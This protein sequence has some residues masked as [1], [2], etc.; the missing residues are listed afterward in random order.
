MSTT[1]PSEFIQVCSKGDIKKFDQLFSSLSIDQKNEFIR[2][3]N[4]ACFHF[5]A[6]NGHHQIVKTIFNYVKSVTDE[7]PIEEAVIPLFSA[8]NGESFRAAL[9]NHHIKTVELILVE[10]FLFDVCLDIIAEN[11]EFLKIIWNSPLRVCILYLFNQ[12]CGRDILLVQHM[13]EVLPK[14][15]QHLLIEHISDEYNILN[16]FTIH[17]LSPFKTACACNKLDIVQFLWGLFSLPHQIKM[18]ETQFPSCIIIAAKN[19]HL[20]IIK[21]LAA[22]VKSERKTSLLMSMDFSA[23]IYAAD[24]GYIEIMQFIWESLPGSLRSDALAAGNFAAYRL[25]TKHQHFP[26]M[27][28]LEKNS[29][30]ETVEKM[31]KAIKQGVFPPKNVS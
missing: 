8:R 3:D 12:Y 19:G 10:E 2:F 23:F 28:F 29:S 22:W 5:A 7:I 14:S 20:D 17:S 4:Y 13:L 30:K 26:V 16:K 9:A 18:I 15:S 1:S 6:A 31:K 25:A 21:Q 24:K 11:K 27:T